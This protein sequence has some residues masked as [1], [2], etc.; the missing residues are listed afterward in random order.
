M[1]RRAFIMV[2]SILL[3]NVWRADVIPV[4]YY[5]H[6]FFLLF[7]N[8][9]CHL[10]MKERLVQNPVGLFL[11]LLVLLWF[12]R[13]L[14]LSSTCYCC[15]LTCL[16]LLLTLLLLLSLLYLWGNLRDYSSRLP[17]DHSQGWVFLTSNWVLLCRL[18][19]LRNFL[20][21]KYLLNSRWTGLCPSSVPSFA[22]RTFFWT[23][24]LVCSLSK[25]MR[26]SCGPAQT[27]HSV[28]NVQSL[29][30]WPKRLQFGHRTDSGMKGRTFLIPTAGTLISSQICQVFLIRIDLVTT[31][32]SLAKV[33]RL[34]SI[35][36]SY[37]W[38][39]TAGSRSTGTPEITL[40]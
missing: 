3:I 4:F 6:S 25:H 40:M 36:F 20:V 31:F 19:L 17:S 34:A 26:V 15:I 8:L 38:T 30:K 14:L 33:S 32:L 11:L 24:W 22:I 18:S 2:F 1:L 39:S 9:P 5:V 23:V 35:T 10:F 29:Q 7:Q 12:P 16:C 28:L 13:L 37:V 21:T 27:P